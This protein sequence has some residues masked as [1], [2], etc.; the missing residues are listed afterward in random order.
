MNKAVTAD[1]SLASPWVTI[2]KPNPRALIRMFCFP[3]AGGGAPIFHN[4][5]DSLPTDIE[6]CVVQM[7][8]RGRR[9]SEAPYGNITNL[10]KGAADGLTPFLD[11]PFVS[12]GHSMGA[13]ISF[14]LARFLRK[15]RNLQPSWL[16]VSGRRAPHMPDPTPPIHELPDPELIEKLQK[17]NGTATEVLENPELMQLMLPLLRVDFALCRSYEH[18]DEPPLDCPITALGGLEDQEVSA[19]SVEAWK[20]Y[21]TKSFHFKMLSGDHFFINTARAPFL[22]ILFRDLMHLLMTSGKAGLPR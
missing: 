16:F 3:Y 11:K 10:V 9:L 20:Q 1:P 14:E 19:E 2:Q 5:A 15:S 4:W 13:I 8:G 6:V 22:R 12:V 21:T 7:P 18:S 17:L